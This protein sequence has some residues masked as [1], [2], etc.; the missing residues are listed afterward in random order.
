MND[1]VAPVNIPPT[2]NCG[3]SADKKVSTNANG[4]FTDDNTASVSNDLFYEL[5]ITNTGVVPLTISDSDIDDPNCDN[6][7]SGPARKQQSGGGADATPVTFDPGDTWTWTCNKTSLLGNFTPGGTYTNTVTANAHFGAFTTP[8]ATDDAVTTFKDR[9]TPDHGG[10]ERHGRRHDP[11]RRDPDGRQQPDGH[12]H[13]QGVPAEQPD[14]HGRRHDRQHERGHG[15]HGH[16]G[17]LH[18]RRRSAATAGSPRTTATPTTTRS[19][20]PATTRARRPRSSRP[21]RRWPRT[22]RT[23]SRAARSTTSPRSAAA[24]TRPGP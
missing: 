5:R 18:D 22:R 12:G 10:D 17:Q 20:G 11:R 21:R 9:P 23:R 1:Y 2:A 14:L 19:A 6:L 24:T 13:L 7:S 16:V 15:R 4:P 3:I 8:D